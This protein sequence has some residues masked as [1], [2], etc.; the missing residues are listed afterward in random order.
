MSQSICQQLQNLFNAGNPQLYQVA[1]IIDKNETF[2]A[3]STFQLS[4][5]VENEVSI[6]ETDLN[7]NTTG[8]EYDIQFDKSNCAVDLGGD[9][10]EVFG[11]SSV[12]SV[13]IYQGSQI[14]P[15][16]TCSTTSN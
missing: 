11:S 5:L 12:S 16:G 7:G 3:Q 10:L 15:N 1:N 14:A 9:C 2:S 6:P 8:I 13:T 4:Q